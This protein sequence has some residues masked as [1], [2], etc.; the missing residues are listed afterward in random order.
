MTF[1][2]SAWIVLAAAAVGVFLVGPSIVAIPASLTDMAISASPGTACRCS[3]T[4]GSFRIANWLRAFSLSLWTSV[5][6]AFVATL[7][8]TTFFVGAWSIAGRWSRH[9]VSLF[10][11]R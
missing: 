6:A 10:C 11:C 3:T 7:L 1:R 5:V 8:G 2:P 9:C 4:S